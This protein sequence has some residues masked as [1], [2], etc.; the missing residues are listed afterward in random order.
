MISIPSAPVVCMSAGQYLSSAGNNEFRM[1]RRMLE[2]TKSFAGGK[3]A[4]RENEAYEGLV[5]PHTVQ[6]TWMYLW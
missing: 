3:R 5:F 6:V 1:K 4:S 2:I